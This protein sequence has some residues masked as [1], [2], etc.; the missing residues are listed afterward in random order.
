MN[1][2]IPKKILL[3]NIEN[4]GL[5]APP[6]CS[7]QAEPGDC[8]RKPSH[9]VREKND[10]HPVGGHQELALLHRIAD[11]VIL[12]LLIVSYLKYLEINSEYVVF[13]II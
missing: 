5:H 10:G 7:G 1:P 2:K 3:L 4:H 13:L 6:S 12:C 11:C 8:L 9:D